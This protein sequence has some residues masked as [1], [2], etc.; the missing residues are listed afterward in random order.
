MAEIRP[1]ERLALRDQLFNGL[2]H[3]QELEVPDQNALLEELKDFVGAI[4]QQRAPRVDGRAA[5]AALEVAAQVLE[6]I[7][8]HQWDGR[9]NGR[10]GPFGLAPH[11][12]IRDPRLVERDEVF[13]RRQAG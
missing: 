2:M 4:K 13:R 10:A 5:I 8:A 9:D 3:Q 1:E 11:E 7:G 12:I 6:S